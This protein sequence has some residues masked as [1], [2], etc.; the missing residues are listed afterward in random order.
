MLANRAMQ[1]YRLGLELASG[2]KRLVALMIVEYFDNATL[3]WINANIEEEEIN[4]IRSLA[5]DLIP[6]FDSEYSDKPA[7]YRNMLRFSWALLEFWNENYF[8]ALKICSQALGEIELS[9]SHPWYNIRFHEMEAWI[10][11]QMEQMDMYCESLGLIQ[12]YIN[13]GG[14]YFGQIYSLE[15]IAEAI[16]KNCE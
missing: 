13:N 15:E 3:L 10:F 7:I 8:K 11:F 6:K 5:E 2:D 4:H 9:E 12:N 16:T 1:S 14:E